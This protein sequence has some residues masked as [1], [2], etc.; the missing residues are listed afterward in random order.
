[1][2]KYDELSD[3]ERS[4]L[5]EGLRRAAEEIRS[6]GGEAGERREM[7]EHPQ[8]VEEL[9]EVTGD[10]E[11]LSGRR[12]RRPSYG[13]R[14]RIDSYAYS[15]GFE[16]C[17][18]AELAASL[19][20]FI[21]PGRDAVR[22]RFLK[23]LVLDSP[24]RGDPT[25]YSLSH[26]LLELQ[27]TADSLLKG[28][29]FL[30]RAADRQYALTAGLRR[31]LAVWEPDGLRLLT[32]FQHFPP[33]VFVSLDT[34]RARQETGRGVDVFELA[35]LVRTVMR[36]SLY[37]AAPAEAVREC[38]V[39]VGELIKA[40]YRR[41][42]SDEDE[43]HR[44]AVRIDRQVEDF[45]GSWDRLKWFAHQLYPPLLKMLRLYRRE[46]QMAAILPQVLRFAGLAPGDLLAM[47]RPLRPLQPA[48][49]VEGG[50]AAQGP[51]AVDLA[52]EFRGILTILGQAFPGCRIERIA[53]ADFSTLF[54]FHQKIYGHIDYRGP[55]I[56]RRPDFN[57]LLA[58][59]SHRD[60]VAVLIVLHELVAQMLGSLV[61]E[62]L[63]RLL[64]PL[65]VGT[66]DVPQQ[67]ADLRAR[68]SLV[69]ETLLLRYLGELND[70]EKQ[71]SL[72]GPEKAMSYLGSAAGRR[73]VEMIN[74]LRNHLIRGYGKVVLKVDRQELFHAPPL[75]AVSR[76][77]CALLTRLVPDRRQ[78]SAQSPIP[79]HR[80]ETADLVQMPPGPLLGQI[81]AWIGAVPDAERLLGHTQAEANRLFLEI[82]HGAADLLDFL[83]S[84]ERSPLHA[85]D[86]EVLLAGEKDKAIREEIERDRTPLRVELRRDFEQT[87]RLTG[88]RSKNEYLRLIP[89]LFRQETQ[90][91]RELC[92][93]IMDLDCF[94]SI[95]D[96]LGHEFGDTLLA[97]A[98]KAVLAACREEDPAVRFGGDE[99]LVV[100][101]AGLTAGITLAERIRGQ[102]AELKRGEAAARLA[103][104]PQQLP[105]SGGPEGLRSIGTLSIGVALGLAPRHPRPCPDEHVLLKRADRML[106]LA[107]SLGGDATVALVDA[108]GLPLTAGEYAEYVW[109]D[110]QAL[111][112]RRRAAGRPLTFAGFSYEGLIAEQ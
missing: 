10:E 26:T 11:R 53:D 64:D 31:E 3:S 5:A 88:L 52:D 61:P 35:E 7:L 94:K 47:E 62:A 84:D 82:L 44:I 28:G 1:M 70:L 76:E 75:Y 93:L 29:S 36:A 8:L 32:A 99:L 103:E 104:L 63:A 108:L 56:S 21:S 24:Y 59:V 48:G 74:Q 16:I 97:L 98:G 33:G 105:V 30:R 18:L 2:G 17:G 22:R 110:P 66:L 73:S 4:K 23:T 42:F 81:A 50:Q 57:D 38:L 39:S 19:F 43:L 95:N 71:L 20:S 109:A 54:W 72:H 45:L 60:P 90:A 111:L 14:M 51:P 13:L 9:R 12:L 78:M 6:A 91:G 27:T 15:E 67:L 77:L 96:A 102:F 58:A 80:L 101:R 68:W 41:I 40:Q 89:T 107:K 106:Y 25:G 87:D 100:L 49:P 85:A 92:F 55:L 79:L 69:R 65:V 83:S 86:G 46:E 37:A 112:E 34:F